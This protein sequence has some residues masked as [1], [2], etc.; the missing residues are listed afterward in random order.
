MATELGM[1]EI[2]WTIYIPP[3][4]NRGTVQVHIIPAI[5][6]PW[7]WSSAPFP[8]PSPLFL[9]TDGPEAQRWSLSSSLLGKTFSFY[10]TRLANVLSSR[11]NSNNKIWWR[12]P[13]SRPW[14]WLYLVIWV[15]FVYFLHFWPFV[16][17]PVRRSVWQPGHLSTK[18][19]KWKHQPVLPSVV[20]TEA[21][22]GTRG[23]DAS[24]ALPPSLALADETTSITKS[25]IKGNVLRK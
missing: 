12:G 9:L 16:R 19:Q 3:E 14:S 7:L 10:E 1:I 25:R 17:A 8:S 20:M 6:T 23:L 15:Y 5:S 4:W 11:G 2:L 18:S 13:F 24:L 21:D 22:T